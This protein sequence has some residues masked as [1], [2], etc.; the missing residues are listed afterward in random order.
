MVVRLGRLEL[1]RHFLPVAYPAV[2]VFALVTA[3]RL[4]RGLQVFRWLSVLV[5]TFCGLSSPPQTQ[6][7]PPPGSKGGIAQP[8]EENVRGGT[9]TKNDTPRLSMQRY[10][11]SSRI[12]AGTA[13]PEPCIRRHAR[14]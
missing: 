2:F 6:K 10:S 8:G 11:K 1:P 4:L 14:M 3:T 7:R 13:G 12:D 5:R 9:H